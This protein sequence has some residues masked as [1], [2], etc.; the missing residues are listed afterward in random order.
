MSKPESSPPTELVKKPE[1]V[2][3]VCADC[4]SQG[5]FAFDT[6]FVM[7]DRYETEVCLIQIA[8]ASSVA[9]I[10]PLLGLD[11]GEIWALV[12][13][14][15]VET[16]V[17]AGQEDLALCVQHTGQIP[18]CIYDVQIAA[19]LAGQD[20]PLSLQKLVQALLN[21]RLHKGKTLTD[22]RRRPLSD[23]Q[24]R[25]AAQ[26]VQ[27]LLAVHHNLT[28]QLEKSKRQTWAKAEFQRFEQ[29][30]LYDRAVEEKL[31][32]VKGTGA[33]RGRQLAV[34]NDL[35]AWR[36]EL[37]CK[38]NRPARVVLKD[39]LL[40]EIAR[41][42]ISSYSQV[43]DLRG[44]N[45]SDSNVRGM[46][47]VARAALNKPSDQWPKPQPRDEETPNEAVLVTLLTALVR[48]YCLENKLAYS[49]VAT[50]H[51]IRQLVRHRAGS[52][53]STDHKDVELLSGWRGGSVGAFLDEVLKGQRRIRIEQVRGQA[54]V[55][56]ESIGEAELPR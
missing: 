17:H 42:G 55:L 40:V 33:M 54:K 1:Q 46:C 29:L 21:I 28:A 38:L 34:V 37:A 31:R 16:I 50:K 14:P 24:I 27:H 47:E 5:R 44:L 22:W 12:A 56:T 43:R 2:A 10:D 36:D 45:L 9:I 35:L 13:D 7:E 20:Y 19:G 4:R 23:A 39:H 18:R 53:R 32:R 6:E 41:T 51:S 49:L 15:K 11:L 52:S 48:S 25:Y 8:T 3:E 30:S 26:D